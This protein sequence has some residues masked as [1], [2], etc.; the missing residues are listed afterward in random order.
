LNKTKHK[1]KQTNL[2]HGGQ[3]RSGFKETSEA[4][5]LTSGFVYDKAEDAEMAFKG[6]SDDYM[7]SRFGN[8][9]VDMFQERM[10]L[11]EGTEDCR[12]T[13]TGMAAVFSSLMCQL[14]SG[15]RVVSSRALFG[16]CHYIIT[17]ILPRYGIEV[18]LV[19]GIDLNQWEKALKK[20]TK[21]IFLETP[22]NPTLEIIDLS[23]VSK[24]AH[25][26]GAKVIVDNVFATP[27][28]QSPTDFGADIVVYSATKHIDG[29]GRCLGGAVLGDKKFCQD[30]LKIF[31][32]HTG[33]SLSPFNAWVL[34]KSLETLSLRVETQSKAAKEIANFLSEQKGISKVI[35]PELHNHPQYSIAQQQMKT[36]GTIVSFELDHKNKKNK[37][38][39]AFKFQNSLKLIKISNNLGDCKSLITHPATTTHQRLTQKERRELSI[40]DNLLRV[41]AG[42]EN[43]DDLKEDLYNSCKSL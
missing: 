27:I 39:A 23:T 37:K 9:T 15:D 6:K 12:A 3:K 22:S 13:A 2:V 40:N 43:L 7:Y 4:L 29:H 41:S 8:P 26:A 17:E 16:S 21:L 1:G 32:R 19:D 31:M 42:L 33:P 36:G 11:L 10:A 38:K 34:L 20:K 28:L 35:Y 30:T 5:Y 25:A 18:V 24:L 14:K